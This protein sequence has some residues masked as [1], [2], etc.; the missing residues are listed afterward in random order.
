MFCDI[1]LTPNSRKVLSLCMQ[2]V[3]EGY[4]L[5]VIT[6]SPRGKW[7]EIR[8]SYSTS[9]ITWNITLTSKWPRWHLKS[10]ASRLFTQSFIQTQITE[11]IKVLR[12]WPLCGE[13]T[14]TGEFPAQRAS[15][16]ENVSIWWRHHENKDYCYLVTLESYHHISLWF[17]M[18]IMGIIVPNGIRDKRIR[19]PSLCILIR[20]F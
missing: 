8:H 5:Q 10:P 18:R 2:H 20:R 6:T 4:T 1:Y 13:F 3:F 14:V 12:H 17:P 16:A 7:V 9:V 15:N 19:I 11:N